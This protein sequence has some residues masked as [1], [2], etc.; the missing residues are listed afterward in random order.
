MSP[1]AE[2]VIELCAQLER[3]QNEMP[4]RIVMSPPV[5]QAML[6]AHQNEARY[7]ARIDAPR[8]VDLVVERSPQLATGFALFKGDKLLKAVL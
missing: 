5:W 2:H 4:D 6:H 7:D 8:F 3:E 1:L